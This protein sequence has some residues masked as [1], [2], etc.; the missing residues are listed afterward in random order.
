M[1][2]HFIALSELLT[3]VSPLDTDL[4][5]EYLGRFSAHPVYGPMLPDLLATFQGIAEG[6]ADATKSRIVEDA[7]L[8]PAAQQLILLWY[9]GAF[10][11]RT[12][13]DRDA[14]KYGAAN[15]YF[16]GLVWDVIRAHAP[17]SPGGPY[18]YWSDPPEQSESQQAGIV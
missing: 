11:T 14:W 12:K 2:E 18:G 4:A 7:R 16:K 9:V 17:M 6:D 15:H 10:Y 8:G 5:N 3:G 13:A 1:L